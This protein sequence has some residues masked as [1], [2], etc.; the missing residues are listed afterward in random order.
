MFEI[1]VT[2]HFKASHAIRTMSG[3]FEPLHLHEWKVDA[4]VGGGQLDSTGCVVD[5]AIIQRHLRSCL[6]AWDGKALNELGMF[7]DT[8]PSTEFLAKCLFDQLEAELKEEGVNLRRVTIWETDNCS[9]TY[10][11]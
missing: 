5:F 1:S 9:A 4:V 11:G 6:S 8:P 3:E 7:L 2:Q 10:I